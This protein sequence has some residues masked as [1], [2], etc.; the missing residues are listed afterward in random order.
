ML[1]GDFDNLEA[2]Q[3]SE[4]EQGT[5]NSVSVPWFSLS[6]KADNSITPSI[7][8]EDKIGQ[9]VWSISCR[10]ICACCDGGVLSWPSLPGL[11]FCFL[12]FFIKQY[13]FQGEFWRLDYMHGRH[14]CHSCGSFTQRNSVIFTEKL[15]SS[16]YTAKGNIGP[17]SSSIVLLS[18]LIDLVIKKKNEFLFIYLVIICPSRWT[19]KNTPLRW[20]TER[21]WDK[22]SQAN[23]LPGMWA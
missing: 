9:W 16:R 5:Q 12:L 23:V 1:W 19:Q 11:W 15:L 14:S 4:E 17:V 8:C 2:I 13:N 18:A 22:T 21:R 20:E 3:N 6:Y 7:C 10:P